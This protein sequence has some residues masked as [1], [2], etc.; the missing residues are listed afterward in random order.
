MCPDPAD[1]EA[2]STCA[3]LAT[4]EELAAITPRFEGADVKQY[5]Y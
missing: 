3:M 4:G 1:A 2:L 5:N